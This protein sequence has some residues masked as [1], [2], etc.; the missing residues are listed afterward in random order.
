MSSTYSVVVY[1]FR[2][3]FDVK[4]MS[5]SDIKKDRFIYNKNEEKLHKI[6]FWRN[7]VSPVGNDR[8]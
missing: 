1:R 7:P 3:V 6:N 2:T 8:H 4:H 5:E